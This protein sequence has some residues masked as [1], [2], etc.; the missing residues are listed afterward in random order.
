MKKTI[1]SLAALAMGSLL[2]AQTTTEPTT[3]SLIVTS[4][5]TSQYMFRGVRLGGTS[6]QP[7]IEYDRGNLA[8]GLWTNFPL[9]DKVVGQS[10]P[11]L[12]FYGS[13]S[14]EVAKDMTIVPGVTF[15]TY[16]NAVKLNGFYKGTFEPSVAFNYTIGGLKI[17]PKLYYDFVLKGPTAEL[18]AAFVA[19]LAAIAS[20]LDF[21]AT[22]G[23]FKLTDYAPNNTPDIKNWG[24]YYLFGVAM[25]FQVSKTS[26]I[27]VG[28]SY[29]AGSNNFLKQGSS[30]KTVNS[31]A[32]GRGAVTV[33]YTITY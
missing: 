2:I 18:T 12:D 8:A 20:E 9:Q 3:G 7:S 26:K 19:P 16:P 10:A 13:Y 14:L 5:V 32:I 22:I 23:T 21:T 31:A 15:Y 33:G 29:S 17:T 11:E 6:F 30:G 1:L 28:W 25:P 24:D 27:T 4:A